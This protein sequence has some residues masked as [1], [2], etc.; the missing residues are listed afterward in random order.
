LEAFSDF[1]KTIF[2]LEASEAALKRQAT[3][4]SAEYMKMVD[5]TSGTTST[6]QQESNAGSNNAATISKLEQELKMKN[7]SLETLKK[8]NDELMTSNRALKDKLADFDILL[9]DSKKK[10]Q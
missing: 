8:Q 9:G 1:I 5:K 10:S 6:K 4:A 3:N 7:S 2:K